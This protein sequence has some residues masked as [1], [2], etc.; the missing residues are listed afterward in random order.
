MTQSFQQGGRPGRIPTDALA[1]VFENL[2]LSLYDLYR[3]NF[4]AGQRTL[5]GRTFRNCRI[6]GPAVM[7]VLD[8]CNF[9]A[10]NFGPNGGDV[11]NLVLRPASPTSVIGTI[12]VEDCQFI[13]CEFFG[14]GFTGP[15]QFLDQLLALETR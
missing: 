5:S 15:A 11:R 1:K 12:P 4:A 8:N 6:E 13:N 3:A 7:L 14:L 10:T 9:D 2:D